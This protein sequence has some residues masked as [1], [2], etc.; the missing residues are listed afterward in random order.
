MDELNIRT[1]FGKKLIKRTIEKAIQ[2]ALSR[3][4][5]IT[6]NEIGMVHKAQEKFRLSVNLVAEMTEAELLALIEQ[7][8]G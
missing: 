4:I 2:K 1:A 7:I 3:Q 5:D 8:G 6:V